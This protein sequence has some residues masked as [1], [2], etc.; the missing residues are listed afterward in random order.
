MTRGILERQVRGLNLFVPTN[1][2]NPEDFFKEWDLYRL[3]ENIENG[4]V[5]TEVGVAFG[6]LPIL[7]AKRYGDSIT[8]V[9]IEPAPLNWMAAKMNFIS[10][11]VPATYQIWRGAL[12]VEDGITFIN[13][14]PLSC[15]G[16]YTG[17]SGIEVPMI[18]CKRFFPPRTSVVLMDCEGDEYVLLEHVPRCR[19]LVV[20]LHTESPRANGRGFEWAE[21]VCEQRA[22]KALIIVCNKQ[23]HDYYVSIGR[24][25]V[26]S[27]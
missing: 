4:D 16:C 11:K 18:S 19:F 20:E 15:G 17:E 7:L 26:K 12:G 23:T 3:E 13:E 22:E 6:L 27:V 24:S 21:A 25:G 14:Y 2:Q 9:G 1:E 5:V 10:H 8:Y